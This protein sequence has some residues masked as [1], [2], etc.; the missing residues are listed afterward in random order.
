MRRKEF[1]PFST[2]PIPTP[3]KI[4]YTRSTERTSPTP[5]L[6]LRHRHAG[7]FKPF[8]KRPLPQLKHK[9]LATI[10][11]LVEIRP[12]KRLMTRRHESLRNKYRRPLS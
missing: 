9:D 2:R 11:L 7:Q 10:I 6:R 4:I 3:N 8:N 1:H 5:N 12:E